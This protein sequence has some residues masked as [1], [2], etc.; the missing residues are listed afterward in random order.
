M[1]SSPFSHH[2]PNMTISHFK[3]KL[4][5]LHPFPFSPIIHSS[6]HFPPIHWPSSSLTKL[7]FI[8]HFLKNPRN[9]SPQAP[10]GQFYL[11]IQPFMYQQNLQNPPNHH[12]FSCRSPSPFQECSPKILSKFAQANSPAE[13]SALPGFMPL[14]AS[15]VISSGEGLPGMAA[16]LM[17]MST[18]AR[19]F[20]RMGRGTWDVGRSAKMA[21]R[22]GESWKRAGK[23]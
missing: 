21:G 11:K 4:Q 2:C 23:L 5:N 7:P 17:A 16:V 18:S 3:K 19:T 15:L 1:N 10:T 14:T 13:G 12:I 20:L 8:F 6:S 22:G 9:S